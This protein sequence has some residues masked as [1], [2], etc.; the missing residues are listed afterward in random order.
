M[1]IYDAIVNTALPV[2]YFVFFQ[3]RTTKMYS[4]LSRYS[5]AVMLNDIATKTEQK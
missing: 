1:E 4:S 5:I 2:K 3:F